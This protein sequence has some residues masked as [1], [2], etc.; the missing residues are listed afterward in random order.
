M[1]GEM[2]GEAFEFAV[3]E[4]CSQDPGIRAVQTQAWSYYSDFEP[5]ERS[6]AR[7]VRPEVARSILFLQSDTDYQWPPYPSGDF[8][9]YNWLCNVLT[10]GWW[11][12]R[13]AERLRLW[14]QH[15]DHSVW[16][17]HSYAEYDAACARPRF[18]AGSG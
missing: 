15:G 13:K 9:I 14:Q 17:F 16:P 1:R 8:P 2:E 11:E 6:V 5:V 12:R 10:F 3:A 4:L 18:L 7:A